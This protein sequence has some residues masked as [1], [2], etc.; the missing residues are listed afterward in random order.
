MLHGIWGRGDHNQAGEDG[1]KV[2]MLGI[3][4]Q[5]ERSSQRRPCECRAHATIVCCACL[6]AHERDWLNERRLHGRG[7]RFAMTIIQ[8]CLSRSR[9]AIRPRFCQFSSSNPPIRGRGEW[10]GADAPRQK[11][12]S[13]APRSHRKHPAFPAQ[14]FIQLLRAHPGDRALLPPSLAGLTA[15]L[16]PASRCQVDTTWPSAQTRPSRAPLRPT[17]A[18]PTF[19]TFAKR[20]SELERDASEYSLICNFGKA[21]YFFR[22]GLTQNRR[23]D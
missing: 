12:T 14:W 22:A 10:P 17:T 9:D 4:V 20:P 3:W 19:V 18:H 15:S 23:A 7:F 2:V 5:G 21:E 13:S 6:R 16:T 1:Q 11:C 8:T